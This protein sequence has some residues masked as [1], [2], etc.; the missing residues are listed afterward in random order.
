MQPSQASNWR[1][2]GQVS[3]MASYNMQDYR[4]SNYKSQAWSDRKPIRKAA[5]KILTCKANTVCWLPVWFKRFY[6]PL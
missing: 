6:Q 5:Q 1:G 4:L 3:F 2:N